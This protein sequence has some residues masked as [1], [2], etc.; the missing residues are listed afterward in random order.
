MSTFCLHYFYLLPCEGKQV[1]RGNP[2]IPAYDLKPLQF[3]QNNNFSSVVSLLKGV[4]LCL[5]PFKLFNTIKRIESLGT[6]SANRGT[7]FK[8]YYFSATFNLMIY[9]LFNN[10]C[11]TKGARQ[12]QQKLSPYTTA[13]PRFRFTKVHVK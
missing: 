9:F 7:N 12:R 4:E 2:N 8:H 11:P 10:L 5:D 13:K 1:R 3:H 6:L